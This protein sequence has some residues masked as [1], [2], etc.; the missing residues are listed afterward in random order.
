MPFEEIVNDLE[1]TFPQY[2]D[3]L[4]LE[5][6]QRDECFK[7]FDFLMKTDKEINRITNV[8]TSYLSS[9]KLIGDVSNQDSKKWI[10][11]NYQHD[12]KNQFQ[13][14]PEPIV[15]SHDY[16]QSINGKQS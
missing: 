10:E 9:D 8:D 13:L 3:K 16:N 1:L 5:H 12:K 11:F 7:Q 6:D 2:Y 15:A 14:L 4:D